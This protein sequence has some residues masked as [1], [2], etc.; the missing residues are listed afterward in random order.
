[1]KMKITIISS[2]LIVI[3]IIVSYALACPPPADTCALNPNPLVIA[4]CGPQCL[5]SCFCEIEDAWEFT[6][7]LPYCAGG[8]VGWNRH[9]IVNG[10]TSLFHQSRRKCRAQFGV[11]GNC[12]IDTIDPTIDDYIDTNVQWV[13]TC[14]CAYY[15]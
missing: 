5:P 12:I 4:P 6:F 7:Y 2:L 9:C 11:D 3:T 14:A 13:K 1:M 15:F 10:T 8:C